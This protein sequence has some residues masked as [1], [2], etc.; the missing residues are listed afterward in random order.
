MVMM[1]GVIFRPGHIVTTAAG[2]R[3]TLLRK[4]GSDWTCESDG[5]LVCRSAGFLRSHGVRLEW[6]CNKELEN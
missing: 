5:E 2:Q 3:Y 1:P 6:D 4:V